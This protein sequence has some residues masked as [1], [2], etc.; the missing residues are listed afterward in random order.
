MRNEI[1]SFATFLHKTG[2]RK[3]LTI[4]TADALK[5]TSIAL[6]E[7]AIEM[8]KG[9]EYVLLGQVTNDPI[10]K[11]FGKYRQSGGSGTYLV[12]VRNIEQ[13]F[14]IDNARKY[15]KAAKELDLPP[16]NHDCPLCIVKIE[17]DFNEII[18]AEAGIPLTVRQGLLFITGYVT[19]KL[20]N[21]SNQLEEEDTT[22]EYL[23]YGQ[24]IE[25]QNRGGLSIPRDRLVFFTYYCYVAF[26]L[27][28]DLE[29]TCQ[30]TYIDYFVEINDYV[31]RGTYQAYVIF[32][33][34]HS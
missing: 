7:Y 10:E 8:L 3:K 5:Y 17:L 13:R 30:K 33:P 23:K 16:T 12:T 26:F 34:I 14:R 9:N 15:L 31:D 24:L 28:Q 25:Q 22:D 4:D 32:Y 1:P 6:S 27:Q 19:R 20:P 21:L 29:Q 11:Q 2:K 18:E